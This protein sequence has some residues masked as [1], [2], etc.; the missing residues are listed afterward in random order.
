MLQ[1]EVSSLVLEVFLAE[2]AFVA[3][4]TFHLLTFIVGSRQCRVIFKSSVI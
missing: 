2:E 3:S 4:L 1:K